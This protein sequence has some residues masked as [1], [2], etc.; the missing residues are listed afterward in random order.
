[1][2]VGFDKAATENSEE[3]EKRERRLRV[4]DAKRERQNLIE[5]R[6]NQEKKIME[7]HQQRQLKKQLEKEQKIM[8]EKMSHDNVFQS[9]DEIGMA[10]VDNE[11]EPSVS[12]TEAKKKWTLRATLRL[13]K[14][15]S[16]RQLEQQEAKS[17]SPVATPSI[18]AVDTPA[19]TSEPSK[20]SHNPR[21]TAPVSKPP[22]LS[23]GQM[24]V[25]PPAETSPLVSSEPDFSDR[26]RFV[27]YWFSD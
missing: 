25:L 5:G 2:S 8:E 3:D 20:I 17:V 26:G 10:K 12:K 15:A 1:M 9:L 4:D 7:E 18:V 21:P 6:K 27:L 19:K 11:Q 23:V 14:P 16:E 24:P 13:N 22:G